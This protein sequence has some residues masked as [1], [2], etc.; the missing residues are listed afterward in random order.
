MPCVCACF[1]TQELMSRTSLET[2]KLD[3][4]DEVSFLKLKLVSMEETSSN[5]QTQDAATKEQN[6]AEVRGQFTHLK[7]Y[8]L[9]VTAGRDACFYEFI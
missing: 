2:Q 7:F 4:M 6:K 5:A 1:A 8:C 3:L 9:K